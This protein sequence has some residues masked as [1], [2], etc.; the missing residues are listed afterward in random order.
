MKIIAVGMNYK[1]HLSE[2]K[3]DE[4]SSSNNSQ[5]EIDNAPVVFIKPDSA[6][7][8]S[9]ASNGMKNKPFFFPDFTDDIDYETE[10]VIKIDKLGR[11]ISKKFAHRYY[12]QVSVGLDLTARSLQKTLRELRLPWEISKGFD[13]S[14]VVGDF[15]NIVDLKTDVQN[16][17]FSMEKNGVICQKVNASQ[18]IHKID[19]IIEYVSRYFTLKIGDLI[20]TGTPCGIGKIKIGDEISTFL[21]D[22]KLVY[23]RIK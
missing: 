2:I 3:I 6:Y 15:V 1:D 20:F 17:N 22:K 23:L 5:S 7:F 12:S 21:E 13:Y 9:P 11:L 18:M 16:C 4:N 14:A 19:E 8:S 10:L